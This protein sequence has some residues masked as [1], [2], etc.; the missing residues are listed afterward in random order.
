MATFPSAVK[1]F[2]NPTATSTTVSP[3]H[4]DQHTD[5]NAEITAIETSLL[6]F[7]GSAEAVTIQFADSPASEDKYV[8]IPYAATLSVKGVV[9][10]GTTGTGATIV[11]YQTNTAGSDILAGTFTSAGTAGQQVLSFTAGTSGVSSVTAGLAV[12]VVKASC[13]TSY[14]CSLSL[15]MTRTA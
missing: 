15:F 5:A 2:T 12:C 8:V 10:S 6:A 14:G 9:C 13:A 4:H 7:M 11:V 1:S 3:A